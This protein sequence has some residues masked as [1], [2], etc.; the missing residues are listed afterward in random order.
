VTITPVNDPPDAVDNGV[1]TP[2]SIAKGAGPVPI[3]VL[4]NDTSAPDS[5][6]TLLIT[7][8]T[9]ATHGAVAI[10]AGGTSLTYDPAGQITG[11][12]SFTY[13]ISDGNGG[14]DTATVQVVVAKE[15]RKP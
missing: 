10:G 6:E 9:Q 11:S 4:A 1:P 8:V 5:G 15:K 12:D 2:I 13:T 14:T 3:A 7:S